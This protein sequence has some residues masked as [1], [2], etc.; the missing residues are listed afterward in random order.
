MKKICFRVDANSK[1]GQGHLF[2]CMT[3][4]YRLKKDKDFE[5]IFAVSDNDTGEFLKSKGFN[6]F[7][8]NCSYMD[9][10]EKEADDLIKI[11]KS[12]NIDILFIDSYYINN[13]YI[14]KLRTYVKIACF[15]Y[16]QNVLNADLII[17]YNIDYDAE[18]Y[19]ENYK[20]SRCRLLL[21]TKYIPIRSEFINRSRYICKKY[22]KNI[23][24]LS[25]GSDPYNIG[26]IFIKMA[27]DSLKEYNLT[28]VVG[29]YSKIRQDIHLP[30]N[31]QIIYNT[32]HLASLMINSDLVISAGGTTMYEVCAI[33]VPAIIYSMVD[34]Q[35]SEPRLLDEMNCVKY[36]GDIRKINFEEEINKNIKLVLEYSY[37]CKMSE[38]MTGIVDGIG[39]ER[40]VEA[41]RG[42]LNSEVNEFENTRIF[43]KKEIVR[44]KL[45]Y[46]DENVIRFVKRNY[47]KVEDITIL[48]F[49]CGAGRNS[50]ALA[51]EGYKVISMDYTEEAID[52]IKRNKGDLSIKA[53]VNK[54]F[55]VPLE[56]DSVD[57]IIADG[58]MFCNGI[59]DTITLMTNLK[60]VLKKN[61]KFWADWRSKKDS[62]F[63]SGRL[64]ESGLYKLNS[65]TKRDGCSYLFCDEKELRC[66][67]ESAGFDIISID[68][69]EYTENNR[70][71]ICSYYH[72][73]AK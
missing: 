70:K 57:V 71:N 1:I 46:P 48:D 16:M 64:L 9:Y 60:K 2:R 55:D 28:I 29:R 59:D 39:S 11:V 33:G 24:I 31:V 50:F 40:I 3:L 23:L 20:T 61:G 62:M 35:E 51:N 19:F 18:Y 47:G 66:I 41:L 21:G 44:G 13:K 10:T 32:D 12:A 65:E 26:N 5:I 8:M 49:G 54:A 45:I 6:H 73:I 43:W 72:V 52:I 42:M 36:I 56:E 58:S 7:Y 38:K 53:I 17:N 69:F 68:D 34:N 14:N 25:G 63:G 27:L 37:R 15:Y 67:Y 22:V 30:K 4:A